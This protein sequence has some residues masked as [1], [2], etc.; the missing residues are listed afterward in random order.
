MHRILLFLLVMITCVGSSMAQVTNYD[1]FA[2]RTGNMFS[3]NPAWV[4]KDDGINVMLNSQVMGTTQS[5]GQKNFMAGVYSQV[6]NKSG[7]GTKVITD[8]RGAFQ[9]LH[10]DV[11]YGFNAQFSE[12]HGVR[13]GLL[14]GVRNSSFNINRIGNSQLIDMSDPTL[15]SYQYNNTQFLVGAGIVYTYQNLDV[16]ASIPQIVS[17]SQV[18]NSYVNAAISYKIET[19]SDFSF[20]PWFSYQNIPVTKSLVGG[21]VKST[22]KDVL[23]AQVGYQNN[24]STLGAVG[25]MYENIGL[26]YGFRLS[27]PDVKE[28]AGGALHEIT[29]ALRIA[30]KKT[31][32]DAGLQALVSRLD[33]VLNQE[34]TSG[35]RVQLREELNNIRQMLSKAEL[36]NSN[37]KKAKL[38]EEQLN[39]IEEKIRTIEKR[40]YP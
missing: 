23:W 30:K 38:V 35:N 18:S 29:F 22:Y 7:L 27:N 36:D 13:L 5:Y 32:L 33:H 14:A 19:K 31:K 4:T 37:P 34:V 25:V 2:F 1:F 3:V 16:M 21:Y 11:S 12:K 20:Q 9:T 26:S 28:V 10:A 8:S 6:G 24:K 40:L 17:T 39:A 15:G